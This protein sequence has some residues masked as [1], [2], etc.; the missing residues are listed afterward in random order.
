MSYILTFCF[1]S[2]VDGQTIWIHLVS[3]DP[4]VG[5]EIGVF[6]SGSL[7]FLSLLPG[8]DDSSHNT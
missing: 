6:G 3:L 7:Q 5:F 8:S 1:I 4:K 2:G